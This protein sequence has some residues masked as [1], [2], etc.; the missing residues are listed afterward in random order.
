MVLI[1]FL[2]ALVANEL[3]EA[4]RDGFFP[5]RSGKVISRKDQPA[6][7]RLTFAFQSAML[8][9]G[10]ALAGFILLRLVGILPHE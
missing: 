2:I 9:A 6:A 8:A 10:L 4:R 7:Y 5:T 3:R 1:L